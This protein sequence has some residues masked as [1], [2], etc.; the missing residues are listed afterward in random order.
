[1]NGDGKRKQYRHHKETGTV[2]FLNNIFGQHNRKMWHSLQSKNM[3]C[4]YSSE[5]GFLMFCM[6]RGQKCLLK[7]KEHENAALFL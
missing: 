1:M 3:H 5:Y 7:K 6:A 4:C 2:V